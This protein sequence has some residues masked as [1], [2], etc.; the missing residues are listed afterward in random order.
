MPNGLRGE[1]KG[2]ESQCVQRVNA[3]FYTVSRASMPLLGG[4]KREQV[5][6]TG[7]RTDA[8]SARSCA[9]QACSARPRK[10]APW[11]SFP[12]TMGVMP[13]SGQRIANSASFQTMHCSALG[14]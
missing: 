4:I 2:L 12:E 14:A 5:P 6:L 1:W 11:A 8:E 3:K 7:Q 10:D 13:K 9:D